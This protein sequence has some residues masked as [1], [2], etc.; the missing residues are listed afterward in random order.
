MTQIIRQT[1]LY[2]LICF[3]GLISWQ[4]ANRLGLEGGLRDETPPS[5]NWEDSDK[6]FQLNFNKN[7]FELSFNEFV[8]LK[9][10]G[11]QIVISPPLRYSLT[12]VSRGKRVIFRFHPDE[13]LL[14][15]TTYNIQFGEAI[16]DITES[17]PADQLRF[18]FSTGN[19][20]DS[21][22]VR[23]IVRDQG[24]GSVV[25]DCLVMLYETL[26]DTV[27][28]S[29]RP[30]YFSRTDSA[31][32]ALVQ[33]CRPGQYRVFALTDAN[34]NYQ[35]DLAEER[36]GHI[37]T[38]I[39]S[40]LD[41]SD[42]HEIN[43]YSE[44][45]PPIQT[46]VT[47]IDSQLVAI[48]ITGEKEYLT[49]RSVDSS[50]LQFY[51]NKDTL[52]LW[53]PNTFRAPFI[54]ESEYTEPDTINIAKLKLRSSNKNRFTQLILTRQEAKIIGKKM[55]VAI[56]WNNPVVN[57]NATN[58]HLF[59][60]KGKQLDSSLVAI[61]VDSVTRELTHVSW[62]HTNKRD[63]FLL[64]PGAFISWKASND[65]LLQPMR[66]Q[67]AESLSN[68]IVEVAQIKA[69]N[70]YILQ[71]FTDNDVLLKSTIFKG[72]EKYK[73]KVEGLFPSKHQLILIT[74][75]N[76][77]GRRDGGWFDARQLPEP[78]VSSDI[79]NLRPDWD[80]QTTINPR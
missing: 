31:G 10:P 60:S 63:S 33:N 53:N 36:V 2:M 52:F 7:E 47:Q 6:N 41:F 28:R 64:T 14:E 51:W 12:P 17:N 15:N 74:D 21:M 13:T 65:S 42:L 25:S 23:A 71:L 61:E 48:T 9:N 59:D 55:K 66:P 39:N 79:D 72:V 29:G 40:T 18:V 4:C 27:I 38:F 20:I 5:V 34:R 50:P 46:K 45:I 73:W 76:K 77:N 1:I 8:K 43:L 3:I 26:S 49:W 69:E 78:Q 37:D 62:N 16:Q 54:L 67:R 19:V 35:F 68:L 11:E 56:W 58:F 75:L 80:V 57:Y 22:H 44:I 32:V 70:Q 24:D 30:T